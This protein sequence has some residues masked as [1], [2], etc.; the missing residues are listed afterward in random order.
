MRVI[1]VYG[2][3]FNP[4]HVGHALV[5]SWIHLT[6]LADRVWFVPSANHPF[7]KE[8]A[9]FDQRVAMCREVAMEL[10]TWAIVSS[11][12]AALPAPNYT[13]NLL[14][15]LQ[16]SHPNDRFRFVMGSDNLAM[17]EKWHGFDD[18]MNEFNP[19]FVQRAGEESRSSLASQSPVFPDVSSTEIRRR[20]KAGEPI[21]HLVPACI[22]ESVKR[23]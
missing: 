9:P 21:S 7:G 1:A 17:R 2:G 10:G 11:V 16:A 20:I 3:A 4:I 19:I 6:G 14:R 12:E 15:H 5:A 13:I 18:I 23:L 8:M 22:L